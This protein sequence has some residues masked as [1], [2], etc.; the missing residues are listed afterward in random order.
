M[1]NSENGGRRSPWT[2]IRIARRI[3]DLGEWFHNMNLQGIQTAPNHFLGDYP[4]VKWMRFAHSIPADLRGKSVLDVGC[5]AGFYS[6]EMKRRGADR[7]VGIDSDPR[8]LAQA[9]FAADV[10]GLDIEFRC[11]SV[12]EV[13]ELHEKFDIVL[14]LGVLYHLR[15]PLLAIDLLR[16]YVVRDLLVVQSML[17]GSSRVAQLEPDYPF[18]ENEV[19]ERCGFPVM[20][21]IENKYSGDETNW[22]IPNNACLEAMLRSAG[23]SILDHPESE[24]YLCIPSTSETH[25]V[26]AFRPPIGDSKATTSRT[27]PWEASA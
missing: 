27:A 15:Y 7:V 17:R 24:I 20:Y 13:A 25:S 1:N 12:Y 3:H 16:Q 10:N 22:W 5:N 11:M 8:Y 21:F 2:P 14:F 6:L 26:P 9:T 4:A 19:F 18:E 23:F